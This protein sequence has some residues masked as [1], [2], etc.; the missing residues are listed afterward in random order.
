MVIDEVRHFDMRAF[1][2]F[3]RLINTTDIMNRVDQVLHGDIP[4]LDEK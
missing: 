4:G 3:Q 2:A 1:L